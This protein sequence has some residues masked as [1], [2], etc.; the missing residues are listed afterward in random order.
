[1]LFDYKFELY[2]NEA[3]TKFYKIDQQNANPFI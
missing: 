3:N 2:Y 1:M